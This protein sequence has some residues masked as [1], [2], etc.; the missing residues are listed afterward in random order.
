VASSDL[1]VREAI[2][3]ELLSSRGRSACNALS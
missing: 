1:S 3:A 2:D